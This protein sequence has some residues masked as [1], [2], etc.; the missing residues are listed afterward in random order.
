M[1]GPVP[2]IAD[3]VVVPCDSVGVNVYASA[4]AECLSRLRK[5]A[6]LTISAANADYFINSEGWVSTPVDAYDWWSSLSDMFSLPLVKYL[7]G[8]LLIC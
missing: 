8:G 5:A 6:N 1:S 4:T 3:D 2:C 7:F